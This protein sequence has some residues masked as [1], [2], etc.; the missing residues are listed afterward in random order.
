MKYRNLDSL[1]EQMSIHREY[2]NCEMGGDGGARNAVFLGGLGGRAGSGEWGFP[3]CSGSGGE[4]S[5]KKMNIHC[6]V[7]VPWGK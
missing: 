3:G 1:Q 6:E 4:F 7:V 2:V 5:G